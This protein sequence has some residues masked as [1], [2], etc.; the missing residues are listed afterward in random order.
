MS[1]IRYSPFTSIFMNG[2]AGTIITGAP[3]SGK[4]FSVLTFMANAL[5]QKQKVFALDPKDDL[6][7]LQDYFNWLE[8][9]DIN[10][11]Q[12]G[13]LNPFNVLKEIDPM[14]ISSIISIICGG[15][16]DAQNNAITPIVSDFVTSYKRGNTDMS[17]YQIAEYLY[18]HDNEDLQNI[19]SKLM[20]CKETKYGPLLFSD[21]V[22]GF[23]EWGNE[24]K[25]EK[26]HFTD[27]S[28]II[29][30]HGM[31]LP[32]ANA[33]D[34]TDDQRF[35]SAIVYIICRMIRELMMSDRYPTLFVVDEAHIA[36]GSQE[37]A[38][39]INDILVLGRSL[40]IATLLAS[41]SVKHYPAGMEQL[42]A[43]TFTMKSSASD[44][45][46]LLKR[47]ANS[48]GNNRNDIE[49]IVDSVSNFKPGDCFMIDSQNRTGIF[50]IVS[51]LTGMT[52][53]PL[54][55]RHKEEVKEDGIKV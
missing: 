4:T 39:V 44:T 18:G 20:A 49:N 43:T 14:I 25:A 52:S 38:N 13:A 29:S 36:F 28:K 23:D 47:F 11:I 53:N 6:T 35:N 33:K 10:N 15:F 24:I 31:N 26:Y 5:I 34:I 27:Q 8:V 50:H 32:K 48:D 40:N 17:M 51:P 1:T 7:T 46:E 42:V 9:I 54:K 21:N 30:L 45:R 41:Q 55:R 16:S 37:F 22:I 19:G 12:E 3:G 2:A